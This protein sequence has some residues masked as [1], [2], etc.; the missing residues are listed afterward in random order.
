MRLGTLERDGRRQ[1]FRRDGDD[2]MGLPFADLAELL[3]A[4]QWRS[5]EGE[6]VA[7]P[8]ADE[9]TAPFAHPSTVICVGLNYGQH[10]AE[11]GKDAPTYPTL[12]A[13]LPAALIGPRDDILMPDPAVSVQVDWEAE[14]VIVMGSRVRHV[15][16]GEAADA[17]LGYTVMNDVSVRDWQ[18]RTEEWLQGKNFDRTTP[19]GP[20]VV[21]ADEFDPANGN[22]IQTVVNGVI[23]QSGSTDDLLFSPA[24][25]VSYISGFMTLNPGDMIATGT[26]A[27]VGVARKPQL[28]LKAGDELVTR[29]DGIGELRNRCVADTGERAT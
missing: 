18:K 22:A 25:I 23:Q 21:T 3:A 4:E 20:V 13:K 24:E 27:G 17:I 10:A 7:E 6:R 19:I 5:I 2:V 26:P 1:V 16:V 15:G 11:V 14:L 28:F 12:F 8:T 9:L 29:I